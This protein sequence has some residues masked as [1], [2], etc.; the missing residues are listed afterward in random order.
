MNIVYFNTPVGTKKVAFTITDKS[1]HDL[2]AEG[3]IPNGSQTLVKPYNENMKAEESAKHIH[4]DKV[5]FDNQDN[6]TDIV[7][8]LDLLKIYFLNLYRQVRSNAFKVLDGYQTRALV[9][10][11]SALVAEIEADKQALRD[12]PQSL[13]YSNAHTG[14]DVARTYPAALLVD[15][16]EKYK[17]RF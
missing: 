6:P 17:S 10:N 2:K 7:F 15:Y 9:S 5:V 1:V 4:I 8:D 11:N 14:L 16:E 3:V 13:D 12:V